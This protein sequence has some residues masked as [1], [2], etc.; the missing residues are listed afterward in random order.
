MKRYGIVETDDVIIG[1]V[2]D[3]ISYLK[4]IETEIK[5][6]ETLDGVGR[7][8]ETQEIRKII[9]KLQYEFIINE[10]VYLKRNSNDDL[11]VYLLDTD[12]L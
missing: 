9:L 2:N 4:Q 7:E 6:K 8:K 11:V 12:L 5:R 3:V 10:V 1:K